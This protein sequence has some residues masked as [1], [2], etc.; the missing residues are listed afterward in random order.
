M[1]K[2]PA[3]KKP[4]PATQPPAPPPQP[5]PEPQPQAD[6]APAPPKPDLPVVYTKLSVLERST[7]SEHGPLTVAEIKEVILN[8]ETER[9]YQ[10]RMVREKPGSKPEHWLFGDVYHC[11]DTDKVKVR[12]WNNANNRPFDA[13]WCEDLVHTILAGQ[14]AGPLTLPGETIN[15]ETVR[16][17]RYGRVLSGQH[18]G[19]A[20]VLADERLQKARAAGLAEDKYPFWTGHDHVVIETLVITGLSEDERVLRTIDYVKPR[21]TADMLYTMEL[22]RNNTPKERQELTRML[23]AAIDLLWTRTDTQGYRTHPEVCGFL[24]RHKRLLKCVEYLFIEN[25]SRADG[26][27]RISKLRIG[28]GHAAALCY[29]MGSSGPKTDGDVYRNESPPSERG[30]DWSYWDR[31]REFWSGLAGDRAFMPVRVALGR[32]VESDAGS[33]DNQGQGGRAPEKLAILAKA[34]E[35]YRDH[36]ATA[37]PPFTENDLVDGGE[38]CLSYSDLD[39]KGNRLPDGQIKLLDVADFYGID[40]PQVTKAG[41]AARQEPPMPA[42]PSREEIERATAEALARR[43]PQK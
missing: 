8:W 22:F 39:D 31:A 32:L 23:S 29:L 10:A 9:E 34:W 17:S 1:P 25:A 30:L 19:T 21:T 42:A 15:G 26:G 12:C 35:L 33:A 18:Q 13:D 27:R 7:T 5:L 20:C 40:C 36:P 38:L 28:A 6:E 11:L 4:T 16:I 14:W 41:K 2:A 37:G 24:E 3:K 43:I